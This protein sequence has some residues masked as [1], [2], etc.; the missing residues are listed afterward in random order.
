MKT[1]PL[2]KCFIPRMDH[3]SHLGT[4]DGD[5]GV[6]LIRPWNFG[7]KKLTAFA[8]SFLTNTFHPKAKNSKYIN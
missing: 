7:T 8:D 6:T 4:L 5:D 3:I 1:K 2:T